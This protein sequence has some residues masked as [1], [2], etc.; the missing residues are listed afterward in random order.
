[1]QL[2]AETSQSP[3]GG[4]HTSHFKVV[5]LGNV[6]TGQSPASTQAVPFKYLVR[7]DLQADIVEHVLHGSVQPRQFPELSL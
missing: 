1:M 7:Q 2:T 3:H 6:P 4:V 5:E